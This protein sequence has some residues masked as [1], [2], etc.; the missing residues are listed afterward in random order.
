[1]KIVLKSLGVIIVLLLVAVV[2]FVFLVDANRF[3]P[4]IE[5]LARDQGVALQIRGD[6]GWDLWPSLGVAVN[7]VRV[8]ALEAPEQSIA[9]LQQASLMLKLM[10][11]LHGE[12]QVDHIVIDGLHLALARD[13]TGKGNWEA[14]SKPVDE[15]VTS[16][17]ASSPEGS[18]L[19]LDVEHIS[20]TNT[21]LAFS[22]AQT[23]QALSVRDIN[24]TMDGVNTRTE[25]FALVLGFVVEQAQPGSEKLTL[26]GKLNGQLSIDSSL[27]NL[28]FNE[29]QL[30]LDISGKGSAA[31]ALA[32]SLN[33]TALQE[34]PVYKGQ[35][36]LKEMNL[37]KLLGALGIELETAR[38]DALETF[39]LSA[40]I[41]GDTKKVKLDNLQLKL[42][43][44]R[45]NG[46]AAVT[47]FET[48]AVRA[49]LNGEAL[50]ADDYLPPPSEQE[51]Q[52]AK[53]PVE[54]TPLPL[55]S[56]R[57]LNLNIKLALQKLIFNKIA[58][59]DVEAQ[60]LAKN[61]MLE[62]NLNATAYKGK[63]AAKGQLDARNQLA[64][65]QFDAGVEG[66]ELEPLL[67]DMEMDSKFGLQGAVQVRALGSSQGNSTNALFKALRANAN[68]SGAQ[69]RLSPINLEQQFCKLVNLV[70]QAEDPARAWE[71][72][73]EM[74]ELS[75]SI[76]LRDQIMTI[77]SFKAGVE[78]LQ[79]GSRGKI[80]LATDEY[81][82]F[83]P[84]K[85]VKDKT[86]TVTAEQVAVTTSANGCSVGS[87]YW[88]ERGLELLRCKGSFDEI[89]PLSDCRPDK[90][91]M[92]ELT[93]DFAVYKV[94]EKHGAK[95]EEKK[96]E[97]K[98]KL[99]DKKQQL[100]DR[101]QKT[102]NRGAASSAA[103]PAAQ[104]NSSSVTP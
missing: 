65:L 87:Y 14:F 9:E 32:Y 75:G 17:P 21:S 101:L 18:N 15:P 53:V 91:M 49:S 67:K 51:T 71:A 77:D 13:A 56:L 58:L 52:Q 10:P 84:F 42:D 35:I 8:A 70:N 94:K 81:D 20:L 60:I 37:R 57:T 104:E 63:I 44:T 89:N 64:Q 39:G 5:S 45:F 11:L 30:Q 83:L 79:L 2:A 28:G 12:F 102:L 27:N 88:L 61:G 34:S 59:Q 97:V 76:K 16:T 22:D 6:L 72:Y 95:I 103:A 33:V 90:E 68:F 41:D 93:K 29:G 43:D 62:H 98:Q 19:T 78:K 86:D 7:D 1:M 31:V 55:D 47:N 36:E 23:G 69:V 25:P 80:N 3:K 38:G 92:V 54:D 46:S 85:L 40:A 100:F 48:G 82:I 73:T 26:A 24:L 74:S 50:N 66:L 4:R 99:E 96:Q